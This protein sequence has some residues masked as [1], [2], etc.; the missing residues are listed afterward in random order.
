MAV[1]TAA[2]AWWR[3]PVP[4]VSSMV[5]AVIGVVKRWPWLVCIAAAGLGGGLA[6][7]AVTK[8]VKPET[9]HEWVTLLD[10]PA[11]SG[12]F[13]RATVDLDGRH[14]TVSLAG[15][16][17]RGLLTHAAG[18]QPLIS[19]R[20]RPLRKAEQW[21]RWRHVVGGLDNVVVEDWRAGSP[22]TRSTNR[23]RS[24]LSH[25]A[26]VMPPKERALFLGLTVGDDRAEPPEMINDFRQSGLS[27]LTAVSGE[28]VHSG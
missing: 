10:D 2:A 14:F 11:P 9:V 15:G 4:I 22:L 1:L 8:P 13:V 19:A 5:A 20:T 25:G 17:G 6:A 16:S 27:H 12:P 28:N 24:L 26:D 3:V 18:E 23:V 7:R 21:L